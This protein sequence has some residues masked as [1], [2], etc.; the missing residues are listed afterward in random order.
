MLQ[1]V[2]KYCLVDLR[3]TEGKAGQKLLMTYIEWENWQNYE[4]CRAETFITD[5]IFYDCY[6]AKCNNHTITNLGITI[7]D[8]SSK[9][10]S[11]PPCLTT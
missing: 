8:T 10:I 5:S 2:V 4:G 11:C 1:P 9:G 7:G 3:H 6:A